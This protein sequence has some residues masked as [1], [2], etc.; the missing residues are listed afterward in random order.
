MLYMDLIGLS[1]VKSFGGDFYTLVMGDDY[2]RFTQTLLLSSKDETV[3]AFI[4]F[5]N[6]IQNEKGIFIVSIGTR[7]GGEFENNEFTN[8]CDKHGIDHNFSTPRTPQ[9]NGGVER[10]NRVLTEMTRVILNKKGIS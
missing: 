8:Y 4:I 10:K 2:S 6:K 7:H 1:R 5:G 3:S 9:Q